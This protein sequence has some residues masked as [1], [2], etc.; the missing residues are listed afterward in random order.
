MNTHREPIGP[1][2]ERLAKAEPD[3]VEIVSAGENEHWQAIRL[4]DSHVLEYLR[5]REC[6]TGD[7]HSAGHQFYSDWYWA[8]LAASGV[9]DPGR[10]IVDGGQIEH[11]SDRKL[12]SLSRWQKAVQ[13]VGKVHSNTL[14]DLLLTEETLHGWGA[15]R[16]RQAN[17]ERARQAAITALVLALEQLDIH[18]HGRRDT[19]T[20]AAHAP[21]YRP[22]MLV[23][24]TGA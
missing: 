6:I 4:V 10:V 9:I 3:Q 1:T 14:I 7:Q 12:F 13:G 22:S 18:Y 2:R 21:D 8:G 5:A 15:R 19:R 16:F 24:E 23:P 20:R 11:A 17:R